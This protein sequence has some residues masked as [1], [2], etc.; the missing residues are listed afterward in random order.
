MTSYNIIEVANVHGGDKS[1][2]LSLLEEFSEFKDGFGIKF[3]PF[4]YDKIATPDYEWYKTY[5][6]LYF[7]PEEWKEIIA[8]AR[9]TKEVWIDV[10]DAYTVEIIAQN[11]AEITGLKFQASVL[12]NRRL[13]KALAALDLSRQKVI[14]NIAGYE[15]EEIAE[16][17]ER[18]KKELSPEELILQVGFQGYPTKL[19]DSG[20]SKFSVL[21]K[22]FPYRLSF[23]EHLAAD[24]AESLRL[25]HA[26]IILGASIIE[27][28]VRHSSLPTKYDHYSSI[29]VAAYRQYLTATPGAYEDILTADFIN[30]RE[31]EYLKK[32]M[33][34]P[35]AD[36]SLEAGRPLSLENDVNFK[37]SPGQGLSIAEIEDLSKDLYILAKGKKPNEPFIREDFKKAKFAAIIACRLKSTRLPRKALLKIGDISSIE[38]CIKHTLQFNGV[39]NVVLATS[40]VPEDAEL[41]DYTYDPAV[42]FHQGDPDD[43]IDRYL[44]IINK[45]GID[46]IVRITGDMQYV[47][48]DIFQILARS[49]FENGADYTVGKEAAV[50]TNLEIINAAALRKV[51][52]YFPRADYSEYM[53]Y[54]FQN[55]PEYFR[56]N[57]VEL[58]PELVRPYR[59]TLDYAEDL[60]MFRAIEKHFSENNLSY[61]IQELFKFLDS[62]PEIAGFNKHCVLKYKTDPEL[63]KKLKEVTTIK[64]N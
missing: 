52:H 34:I 19:E 26:A 13:F 35:L 42:I 57:F 30:D 49:H 51:K 17:A 58:P 41:K 14:V 24:D 44:G 39:N 62:H 29:P 53:T 37:R 12:H 46:V 20:L 33:Q 2:L 28:H 56:L 18:I 7:S 38:L 15:L 11:L 43:V 60:E 3:Q 54:Y 48:N 50:G 23:T 25:P 6:E 16:L 59:L 36:D 5:Q 9:E 64:K 21:A 55:N 63:I 40:T 4:K 31:R 8:K 22:H 61:S 32:T 47:S 1:H 45:L 10:F 27:K